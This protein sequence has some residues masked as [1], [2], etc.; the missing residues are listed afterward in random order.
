MKR[1]IFA[2]NFLRSICNA[3]KSETRIRVLSYAGDFEYVIIIESFL[4]TLH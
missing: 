2:G 1:R 3:E 4:W